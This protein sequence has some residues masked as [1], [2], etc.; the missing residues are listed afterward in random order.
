MEA[1]ECPKKSQPINQVVPVRLTG[2]VSEVRQ[3]PVKE[4]RRVLRY[5]SDGLRGKVGCLGK[6]RD[7]LKGKVRSLGKLLI[8]S[9]ER[10]IRAL[11]VLTRIQAQRLVGLVHTQ[12]AVEQR[13]DHRGDHQVEHQHNSDRHHNAQD[14]RGVFS[15]LATA[16]IRSCG[17]SLPTT[18]L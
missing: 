7:G 8:E 9:G 4:E 12:A 6:P 11:A 2:W 16:S 5:A 1:T 18:C 13:L 14:L 17:A 15:S 3:I 10:R